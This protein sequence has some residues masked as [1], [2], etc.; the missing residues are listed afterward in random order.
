MPHT[1]IKGI[2]TA[3]GL[4]SSGK[5]FLDINENRGCYVTL[6]DVKKI[7]EALEAVT[8]EDNLVSVN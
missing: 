6:E 5:V 1:T 7:T 3:K 2:Y 8:R 4:A